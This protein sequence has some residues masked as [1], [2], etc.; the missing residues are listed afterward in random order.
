MPGMR[1]FPIFI[2]LL[3]ASTALSSRIWVDT[4]GRTLEADY[5][6][7]DEQTVTVKR[8]IDHQIFEI[9]LDSLSSKDRQYISEQNQNSRSTESIAKKEVAIEVESIDRQS[10]PSFNQIDY[11]GGDKSCGPA[12]LLNFI[13]W[14][15]ETEY[16]DSLPSGN[17]EQQIEKIQRSLVN[18]CRSSSGGTTLRDL[19][20]GLT[21][22]F[23][24]K[25]P[26]YHIE[27]SHQIAPTPE[28][29][30]QNAR[31]LNGVVAAHGYYK[32]SGGKLRRNGGHYTSVVTASDNEIILN[33]WGRQYT[34]AFQ[35][36]SVKEIARFDAYLSRGG[37]RK[38]YEF[39]DNQSTGFLPSGHR[40]I[41]ETALLFKIT[42]SEDD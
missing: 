7:S 32:E 41:I 16:P 19:Q 30:I 13:I 29:F 36:V 8:D 27:V 40:G 6:E 12:S 10:I 35:P 31:G 22:Y 11:R 23:K 17:K 21:T 3:L 18:Y 33:T 38:V 2:S 9:P 5:V 14:W 15:G 37:N 39:F 1:T 4:Q 42:K 20:R 25:V 28:W 34:M 24:K 26:G